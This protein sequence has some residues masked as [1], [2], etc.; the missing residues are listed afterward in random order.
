MQRKRDDLVEKTRE[1]IA[2]DH[3]LEICEKNGIKPLLNY[4]VEEGC[5]LVATNI[6]FR[7]EADCLPI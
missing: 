1:L 5:R 4:S 7:I 3:Y 2:T 6:L